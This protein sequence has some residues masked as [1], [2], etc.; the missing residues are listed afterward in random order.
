MY[1]VAQA[2][3]SSIAILV[4]LNHNIMMNLRK[5]KKKWLMNLTNKNKNKKKEGRN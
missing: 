1:K 3:I 5:I 2:K 4:K